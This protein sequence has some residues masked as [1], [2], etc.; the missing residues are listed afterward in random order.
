MVMSEI[1]DKAQTGSQ[2]GKFPFLSKSSSSF[3]A[4]K[5]FSFLRIHKP[6][7]V[8]DFPLQNAQIFV[9]EAF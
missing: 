3:R 9:I 6:L 1:A 2:S 8:Q 4:D 5:I 7:L